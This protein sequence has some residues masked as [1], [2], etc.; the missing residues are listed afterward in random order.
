MIK[1]KTFKFY[2]NKVGIEYK[3]FDRD[4]VKTKIEKLEEENNIKIPE[5][6]KSFLLKYNGGKTNDIDFEKEGWRA[7]FYGEGFDVENF[8]SVEEILSKEYASYWDVITD[9]ETEYEIKKE[10]KK[11]VGIGVASGSYKILI[12][13][14]DNDYG[15]VYLQDDRNR[16]EFH[17]EKVT[18]TFNEFLKHL[19]K[20]TI[21]SWN[22]L[23]GQML[24]NAHT[25]KEIKRL[26]RK[27]H[28]EDLKR[29]EPDYF[30]ILK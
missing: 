29:M 22:L 26:I 16:E 24:E 23:R 30:E 1:M 11:Y 7:D 15:T 2:E 9:Q 8:L 3:E 14:E 12:S 18:N 27:F 17:V 19:K 28:E 25:S 5:D 4:D 21:I 6:Y 13:C 10:L 20:N